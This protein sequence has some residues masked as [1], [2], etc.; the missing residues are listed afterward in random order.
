M[1]KARY[2]VFEPFRLD[3]RDERLWD[4]DRT[5]RLGHKALGVLQSLVSRSGQLVTKDDL[6]AAGWPDT[7]VGEAV[8]TTAVRE[9]RRG[10]GGK[11]PPPP[12]IENV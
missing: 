9:L 4:G 12:V 3:L 5:I 2:V 10:R 1:A 8:L 11:P 7:V 6:L